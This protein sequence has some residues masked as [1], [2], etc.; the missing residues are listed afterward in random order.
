MQSIRSFVQLTDMIGTAGQPTP[1]QVQLIKQAG[2][3]TVINLALPDHAD[4]FPD[5]GARVTGLGLTYIHLPVPFHRPLPGHVFRFCRLMQAL[6]GTP[7]FVHCIMN[8]R[9][10]AFM[11][12]YLHKVYGRSVEA[13][14][15]PLFE[16]W[17]P[18]PVWSDLLAWPAAK[19]GLEIDDNA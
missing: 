11:F 6:E 16:R 1:D 17:S 8:Y 9:V 10:S 7:V 13:S 18:D 14:R 5:E 12:H 4:A 19:I 2:Y 15:S 3:E